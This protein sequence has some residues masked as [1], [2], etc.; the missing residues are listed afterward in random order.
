M[1][2]YE[3][4]DQLKFILPPDFFFTREDDD[5]GNES[6]KIQTGEYEDDDG[7][8]QYRFHCNV[9]SSEF[10]PDDPEEALSPENLLHELIA[11]LECRKVMPLSGKPEALLA[12]KELPVAV[13][14][15][16]L[17]MFALI[18]LM[19]LSESSTAQLYISA[20]YNADDPTAIT[21]LY[22]SAFEVLKAVRVN[23][24]KLPLGSLT[25]AQM[26]EQ[27][28]PVFE[29]SQEALDV[30]PEW[31]FNITLGDETVTYEYTED[32]LKQVEY[33]EEGYELFSDQRTTLDCATTYADLPEMF[34]DIRV[35]T[36]Q[37]LITSPGYGHPE[38]EGAIIGGKL[39]DEPDMDA[40]KNI[41]RYAVKE[42]DGVL[43]G[44]WSEEQLYAYLEQQI[45]PYHRGD[46]YY[47]HLSCGGLSPVTAILSFLAACSQ[48]NTL[49]IRFLHD[50]W[51]ARGDYMAE[52]HVC[53]KLENG[54]F[55]IGAFENAYFVE[56]EDYADDDIIFRRKAAEEWME[57]YGSELEKNPQITFEGK[58][59][60]FSGLT[61]PWA[62]KE[63][64]TVLRVIE[65]GGQYRTTVSGLT[66]YLV[67]DPGDAGTS[68]TDSALRQRAKGKPVKIILLAD[69]LNA[70]EGKQPVQ[71]APAPAPAPAVKQAAPARGAKVRPIPKKDM[72][73]T[74]ETRLSIYKGTAEEILIPNYITVIG[75][76]AFSERNIRSVIIPE[77]VETIE[78]SAF[79]NCPNLESVT[80]PGTL[81]AI[82]QDAFRSCPALE[83][84]VIPEGVTEVGVG[85]FS[86]CTGLK[87]I[88][89]PESLWDIGYD[90]FDTS[91]IDTVI[92]APKGSDGESHAIE[93]ELPYDNNTLSGAPVT[94]TKSPAKA[95]KPAQPA[96]PTERCV[97]SPQE[98]TIKGTTLTGYSGNATDLV[99][100]D[101]ITDIHPFLCYQNPNI[102]SVVIPEGVRVIG[103]CAFGYC[104]NLESVTLPST[105]E[106]LN[107]FSSTPKLSAIEIPPQVKVVRKSAFFGCESLR[108]VILPAAMTE[109][110]DSAFSNCKKLEDVYIPASVTAIHQYAFL[111]SSGI[112]IHTPKG[113][114]AQQFAQ[115]HFIKVDNVVKGIWPAP[116]K[117]KAPKA[118]KVAEAEPVTQKVP[119]VAPPAPE[120][121]P[122]VRAKGAMAAGW[123]EADVV[124]M[125]VILACETALDWLHRPDNDFYVLYGKE[126]AAL[127][128]DQI[129][130]LRLAVLEDLPDDHLCALYTA[131]FLRRGVEERFDLS[132]KHLYAMA[133]KA[134]PQQKA[135]FAIAHTKQWYTG[136]ENLDVRHLM[137]GVLEDARQELT[138]LLSEKNPAWA[139]F[140]TAKSFLRLAVMPAP[141]LS[142][143]SQDSTD[144]QYFTPTGEMV[145]V[146]LANGSIPPAVISITNAMSWYWGVTIRDIW[147]TAA[148]NAPY[149]YRIGAVNV[150]VL[151][152]QAMDQI[153]SLH[154]KM[155]V[156]VAQPT[157]T[158]SPAQAP[159]APKKK[160]GCYIA[161]AV[162]GSY[163][164]PQVLTLRRFRDETLRASAAGRWF[165]RAYYRLSP[166]VAKRLENAGRINKLV[167]SL[168][169]RFV[170]KLDKK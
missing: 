68:K 142:R 141:V 119:E 155:T 160:E 104:P 15:H 28:H 135:N 117:P 7:D 63:H 30:S 70:L 153:R 166:P 151:V 78:D 118:P 169:D 69:L 113:S 64:P 149:D 96:A 50:K 121:A 103:D 36:H 33:D 65:K 16:V 83:R 105:L 152:G 132:T 145:Y 109:I 136:G 89:L 167:R 35:T 25:A 5:E 85:A 55:L 110:E 14:G 144:F 130:Q 24:K 163:D 49:D 98:F 79:W 20:R 81:T 23:G 114:F 146:E 9:H 129:L 86:G 45:K 164:A 87:D 115:A 47:I 137:N 168:L 74:D 73:I 138:R 42:S 39:T 82:G 76:Y 3:F 66:D 21:E 154:T 139:K 133:G 161:T 52:E 26:Y 127:G 61:G 101:G 37:K 11:R 125:Y 107:G 67:V 72:E 75:E 122:A 111:I 34:D 60:V 56:E 40:L 80:L 44:D 6:V 31:K 102:V 108:K 95:V 148:A 162:Y 159:A 62:Q 2:T 84:I 13:F 112:T 116:K 131:A 100:P 12:V 38:T 165:I 123:T 150:A 10:D 43:D 157:P 1:A 57:T 106:D 53:I 170:A 134:D 99:L 58:L 158:P 18:C 90:S 59:F 126:F 32:G 94:S 156:P 54:K 17:N 8:I 120:E 93:Y 97:S 27:L 19:R 41:C 51:E 147:E 128:K 124:T 48:F 71:A 91:C 140:A 22:E 46:Q 4:N 77:G 88:Y 29:D 143:R 92:H